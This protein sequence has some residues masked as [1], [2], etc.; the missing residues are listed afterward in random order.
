MWPVKERSARKCC[1]SFSVIDI[2]NQNKWTSVTHLKLT[3][4]TVQPMQCEYQSTLNHV[5]SA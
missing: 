5:I 3:A 2:F 1:L 4:I